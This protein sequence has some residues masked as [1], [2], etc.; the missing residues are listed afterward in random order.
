MADNPGHGL[1]ASYLGLVRLTSTSLYLSDYIHGVKKLLLAIELATLF[2]IFPLLIRTPYFPGRPV[3]YLLFG[4]I[5]CL[6]VLKL[7][8]D[9]S[10]NSMKITRE[11]WRAFRSRR[12]VIFHSLVV[13]LIFAFAF[14]VEPERFLLLP[15]ERTQ[16]WLLVLLLYPLLS[17]YPQELVYRVFFFHR[18]RA[19]IGEGNAAIALNA[20]LFGF[21]HIIFNSW[22][23][24]GLTTI[25]G[26]MFSFT[27][28]K[29]R[30]VTVPFIQH[31]IFGLALFTAGLG[32]HFYRVYRG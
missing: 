15:R 23:S 30:N 10:W 22:I 2:V 9:F 12:S 25:G 17:A 19:I 1:K 18:Y 26:V 28:L 5:Y 14:A 21:S 20:T 11:R 32:Q 27:F 6:I 24:V 8:S 29:S 13:A 3:Q 16:L 4:L 7:D 31:A